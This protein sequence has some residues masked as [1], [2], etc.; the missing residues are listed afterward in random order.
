M[1]DQRIRRPLKDQSGTIERSGDEASARVLERALRRGV[2][3]LDQV[4]HGFH[5]YPARLH[6]SIAGELLQKLSSTDDRILDPF[7]GSGTVLVEAVRHRRKCLGVDLNPLAERLVEVKCNP[8]SPAFRARFRKDL[9]SVCARSEERV[10]NRVAV[11]AK[12]PPRE[13]GWY[14][15][16]T[17]KELAGL[18]EELSTVED[19]GARRAMEMIFSANLTKF[20]RQRADTAERKVDKRIRK[21]LP[22][23]FFHRKGLE[24]IE[25]WEAL[26]QELDGQKPVRPKVKHGDVRDLP[27]FIGAFRANLVVTSPPYGG[28]YDYVDHHIRRY[29]W[30]GIDP[31][32]FA[33]GEIGARRNLSSRDA[34][35]RWD[36]ELGAALRAIREVLQPRG[37]AAFLIGDAEI[38]GKRVRADR[39]LARLAD[40][41]RFDVVARASQARLDRKGGRPRREHLV[42][43]RGRANA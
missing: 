21:G 9:D 43:L 22:T 42:L 20:S 17:L 28:T 37:L 15:G 10:R 30:L 1:S 35:H 19:V 11:R 34:V 31:R 5:S 24:L 41:E 36:R 29:P 14:Q 13:V 27:R 2:E 3:D 16:H 18:F 12:L 32:A 33:K 23:E 8:R 40:H 26:A 25:R 6:P 38:G 4:T 39:Q 7:C